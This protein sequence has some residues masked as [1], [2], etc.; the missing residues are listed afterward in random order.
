MFKLNVI[1]SCLYFFIFAVYICRLYSV[2]LLAFL[3]IIFAV[4]LTHL[5]FQVVIIGITVSRAFEFWTNVRYGDHVTAI[6][7]NVKMVA[8]AILD[9]LRSDW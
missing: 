6:K 9:F 4:L 2:K 7:P 5:E 8:A 3:Y 1:M